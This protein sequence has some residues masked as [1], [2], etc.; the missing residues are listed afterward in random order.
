M[1]EDRADQIVQKLHSEIVFITMVEMAIIVFTIVME[2]L[3]LRG[4]LKS[5]NA[6]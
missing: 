1:K 2:L 6:I 3:C 4:L 5:S